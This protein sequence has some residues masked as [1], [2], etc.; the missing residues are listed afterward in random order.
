MLHRIASA[1]S[2]KVRHPLNALYLKGIQV[3][4]CHAVRLSHENHIDWLILAFLSL[5]NIHEEITHRA[6]LYGNFQKRFN[7]QNII[8]APYLCSSRG[9]R[10]NA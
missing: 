3:V 6:Q 10:P 8:N 4:V 2:R 7:G 5:G 9:P 1:S